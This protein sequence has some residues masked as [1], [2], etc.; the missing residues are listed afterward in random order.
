MRRLLDENSPFARFLSRVVDL[1]GLDLLWAALCLP[2]VTAG[3]ATCALHA[4]IVHMRRDEPGVFK[5]FFRAFRED[6]GQ[7]T[8]LW[9]ILAVVGAGLAASFWLT[10]A[11]EGAVAIVARAA[12][13]VPLA[14]LIL[15]AVYS[16]PLL[17][18]FRVSLGGLLSDCVLLGLAHFPRTVLLILI[19]LA[20]LLAVYFL[21]GMA[22][23]V[24]IWVPIGFA[25]TALAAEKCLDP[26]ME[27][28]E[29]TAGA[30]GRKGR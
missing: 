22:A 24:F 6:F 12:L 25:L 13:C 8:A 7:A 26:V 10:G 5:C 15:V 14:L 30:D 20:P 29:R 2:V 4:A 16:F 1:C 27:Q 9:L 11:W 3:A 23:A 19:G 17:A 28:L 21:G 18:R